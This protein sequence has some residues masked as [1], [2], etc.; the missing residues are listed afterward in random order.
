M[1]VASSMPSTSTW[2]SVFCTSN[3]CWW[4]V[5]VSGSGS[6]FTL[7]SKLWV[8]PASRVPMLQVTVE[9]LCVHG[10][11][12]DWNVTPLGQLVGDDDVLGVGRARVRHRQR[13]GDDVTD[14]RRQRCRPTCVTRTLVTVAWTGVLVEDVSWTVRL[15]GVLPVAVAVLSTEPWFTSAWVTV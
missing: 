2:T 3:R 11:S 5:A 9:P 8:S 4:S 14:A 13:V 7:T 1:P 6:T 10:L 15:S 12:A